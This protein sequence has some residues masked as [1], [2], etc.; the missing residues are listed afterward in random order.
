MDKTTKTIIDVILIIIILF[1][2][3]PIIILTHFCIVLYYFV[4]F[5]ENTILL[6][7]FFKVLVLTYKEKHNI[8]KKRVEK[9]RYF[10]K[11]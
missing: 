3:S 8:I 6:T 2:L 10:Q 1:I 4:I 11:L 7:P 5:L 9:Q